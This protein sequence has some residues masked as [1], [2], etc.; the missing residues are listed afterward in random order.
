MPLELRKEEQTI[1]KFSRRK[2]IIKIRDKI[3]NR[4]FKNNRE[5]QESKFFEKIKLTNLNLSD[6]EKKERKFKTPN[7]K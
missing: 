6:Q 7:Q 1:P 4:Y 5:N 3:N 2:E